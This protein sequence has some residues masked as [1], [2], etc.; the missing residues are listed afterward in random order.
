M[1]V[2]MCHLSLSLTHTHTHTQYVLTRVFHLEGHTEPGGVRDGFLG[3]VW[4]REVVK[5]LVF[6]YLLD[7]PNVFGDVLGR[8]DGNSRMDGVSTR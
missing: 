3:V 1:F 4:Q 7:Q 2:C 8:H 6:L 5:T